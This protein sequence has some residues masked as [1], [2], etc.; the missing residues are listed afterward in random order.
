MELQSAA[1][2]HN[3]NAIFFFEKHYFARVTTGTFPE[4][5]Q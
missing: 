2:F 5:E 3:L 1:D 4:K